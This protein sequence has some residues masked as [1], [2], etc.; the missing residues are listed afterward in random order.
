MVED[1]SSDKVSG[2]EA[3]LYDPKACQESWASWIR[4]DNE[5]SSSLNALEP[6]ITSILDGAPKYIYELS[7]DGP[8]HTTQFCNDGIPRVSFIPST[9]VT[10]PTLV[11][12]G[13][14]EPLY[15][16]STPPEL[17]ENLPFPTCSIRPNDCDQ[18]WTMLFSSLPGI[19]KWVYNRRAMPLGFRV[20][21]VLGN[22][23]G[24]CPLPLNVCK[25]G[26]AGDDTAAPD[27]GCNVEAGR[28]ALISFPP[29]ASRDICADGGRGVAKTV[30]WTTAGPLF[31]TTV[32]NITFGPTVNNNGGMSVNLFMPFLSL[33]V[34]C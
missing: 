14:T 19:E 6:Y 29:K 26:R 15:N 10:R 4:R 32:N 28:F 3:S 12:D 21:G 17:K 24:G 27:D 23:F 2:G 25:A 13:W 22:W 9:T 5:K 34:Y 7:L 16:I 20:P 11:I 31:S 33:E 1:P 30:N 18:Q 8:K